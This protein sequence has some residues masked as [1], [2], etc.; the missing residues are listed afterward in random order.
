M[1]AESDIIILCGVDNIVYMHTICQSDRYNSIPH[2]VGSPPASVW[3]PYHRTEEH[4]SLVLQTGGHPRQVRLPLWF[5]LSQ[6]QLLKT[7]SE[8]TRS[9]LLCHCPVLVTCSHFCYMKPHSC[10]LSCR[11][12]VLYDYFFF[13]LSLVAWR[14]KSSYPQYIKLTV[15]M[16]TRSKIMIFIGDGLISLLKTYMLSIVTV[17]LC[18]DG[19]Q[20]N[21]PKVR[22][23]WSPTWGRLQ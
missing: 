4:W 9:H 19:Q 3:D 2:S 6:V 13:G 15:W 7:Q 10:K 16:L 22:S 1:N 12:M 20:E 14:E 5:P 18:D 23:S 17:G 21:C 8:H 11:R